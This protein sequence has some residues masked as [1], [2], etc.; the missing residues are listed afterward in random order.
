VSGRGC[1]ENLTATVAEPSSSSN[2]STDTAVE[3]NCTSCHNT[4]ALSPQVT[5][6]GDSVSKGSCDQLD[7]TVTQCVQNLEAGAGEVGTVKTEDP[8]VNIPPASS[9]YVG[10][11][12]IS[13]LSASSDSKSV[14]DISQ[15]AEQ[16]ALSDV[17]LKL[18]RKLSSSREKPQTESTARPSR[19]Q[20]T[21]NESMQTPCKS[22]S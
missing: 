18:S 19:P 3:S 21:A 13:L 16:T 15:T 20:R 14:P 2:D 22:L 11:D 9:D 12:V 10:S 6:V 17:Q 1:V 8:P 4:E 5:I 7:C